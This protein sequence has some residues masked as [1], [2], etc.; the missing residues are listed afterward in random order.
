MSEST[1]TYTGE[2]VTVTWDR[3]RCLHSD[4]CVRRLSAVFDT[5]RRPWVLPDA[6]AADAVAEAV[7][8]CPSGALHFERNDG[9]PAETPPGE[10]V[11]LLNADGP[12]HVRGNVEIMLP[13]GSLLTRDTRLA[14]CR[15]GQ[16]A[17]KPFCDNSHLRVGFTAPDTAQAGP[18]LGEFDPEAGSVLKITP[19]PN[20]SLLVQGNAEIRNRS[21]QVIY[22]GSR[23]TLC[24]C[25]A[26]KE[27]PFCDSTHKTNGWTG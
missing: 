6:A 16:S 23:V 24:R 20:R 2:A 8:H 12:L 14:L 7:Q 25:G 19:R 26:S 1:K 9:G 13:D 10:N 18:R 17:N 27:T 21:G 4:E 22:R 15:C 5:G 11:L 3:A